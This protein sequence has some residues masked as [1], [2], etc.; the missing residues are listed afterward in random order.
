MLNKEQWKTLCFILLM[1]LIICICIIV[2][3]MYYGFLQIFLQDILLGRYVD[4]GYVHLL[5]SFL[6]YVLVCMCV[7]VC[8]GGVVLILWQFTLT[9]HLHQSS[10]LSLLYTIIIG[11]SHHASLFFFFFFKKNIKVLKNFNRSV[12]YYMFFC[13]N[14]R[15]AVYITIRSSRYD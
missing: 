15:S 6:S 13:I 8:V 12:V 4:I 3:Y 9:F 10:C 7:C 11:L 5:N 1:I 14:F 2:I